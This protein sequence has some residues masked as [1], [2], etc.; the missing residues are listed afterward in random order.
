MNG[1][2]QAPAPQNQPSW[3]F[4]PE[5]GDASGAPAPAPAP[6]ASPEVSWTASEFIA[7]QKGI[8]WYAALA[9]VAVALAVLVYVLTHDIISVVV[10][11][12][13]GVLFGAVAGNRPRELTYRVGDDGLTI[14]RRLYA[15]S[16]FKSFSLVHEGAIPSI[17]LLPLRRFMPPLT[18]YFSP[19]DQ[20]KIVDALSARLPMSQESHDM[21]DRFIS[22]IRF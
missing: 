7:H 20:D 18:V 17:V 21:M 13:V 3:Q 22:R 10:V 1:E 16:E 11:L 19:D 12:V 15:Y 8:G 14:G 4:R 2:D 6:P 5:G 9:L